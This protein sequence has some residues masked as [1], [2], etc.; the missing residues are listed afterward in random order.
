M[1]PQELALSICLYGLPALLFVGFIA[2]SRLPPETK[3]RAE[4]W[5]LMPLFVVLMAAGVVVAALHHWWVQL[6]VAVLLFGLAT[7]QLVKRLRA[8]RRA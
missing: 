6:A 4:T 8:H 2:G 1:S 7:Q 3:R 5:F